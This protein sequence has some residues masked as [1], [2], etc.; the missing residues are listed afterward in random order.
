MMLLYDT[1]ALRTR[2]EN[3]TR[4]TVYSCGRRIPFWMFLIK[5][6]AFGRFNIVF[7]FFTFIL[8]NNNTWSEV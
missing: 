1:T 3:I 8:S 2:D 4:L 6:F 7:F 5:Y